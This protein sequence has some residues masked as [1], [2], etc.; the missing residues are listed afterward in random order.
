MSLWALFAEPMVG[1]AGA[2]RLEENAK[3]HMNCRHIYSLMAGT[4]AIVAFI[5]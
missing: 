3:S 1:K 4:A 5:T 2:K